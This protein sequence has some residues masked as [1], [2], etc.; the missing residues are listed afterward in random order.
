[1]Y[2]DDDGNDDNDN[3]DCDY[4]SGDDYYGDQG[5]DD[6]YGDG[7]C[8]DDDDDDD[9]KKKY[10]LKILLV[11]MDCT[12]T[13]TIDNDI[14][15]NPD[16]ECLDEHIRI[17]VKTRK[18]FNGRI[19]AKGK[20]DKQACMKDNFA[21]EKTKKPH[22]F[23]KFGTC[24]MR[25]LR[26]TDPRGMYYGITIV[27]SFHT[28]F[29]TKVDQAF[30]V[31][32][33]FEEAS[34]GLTAK[35]G[36][37]MIPTTEMEARHP[38]PGCS[39]SIHASSIN[40]IE[41]GRPAGT[42]IK[43][44]RIG[45]RVLHQ[46]H[47]DDQ[48]YGI[49]I[50]NCYVTDGFGKRTE[51]IDSNGCSID[52]ILI[53]SIRYSNDLQRAYGESTVFK[54]ADRPGVWFFCQI[55]MCMKKEGM[56]QGITPPACTAQ[57]GN[58]VYGGEEEEEE[59]QKGSG[60][61]KPL[62]LIASSTKSAKEEQK[63]KEENSENQIGDGSDESADVYLVEHGRPLS[64]FRP[65]NAIE[66]EES[67]G[68]YDELEI[69]TTKLR[70][71]GRDSRIVAKQKLSA[72]TTTNALV[73]AIFET[74]DEY[75]VNGK[76]DDRDTVKLIN[77]KEYSET[78]YDDLTIA[79]N[80]NDLLANLPDEVNAASLQKMFYDS[81]ANRRVLM[82]SFDYLMN[83][84]AWNSA[85]LAD[86]PL[87]DANE[88]GHSIG[89]NANTKLP[90]ISDDENAS[91]MIAGQLIIYDLDEEPPAARKVKRENGMF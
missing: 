78:N 27:V 89:Q 38:I 74:T 58:V 39:Y 86:K 52:P 32:C 24:G 69:T 57:T 68:I 51:V 59:V 81:V 23:L 70:S 1:M 2:D 18:I 20:A 71:A 12:V 21:Q 73:T 85:R 5:D 64:G 56:C 47:C 67:D 11:V 84:V 41:A 55:Q 3:D 19:Y 34:H 17:F 29:I 8:S 15:G 28:V 83:Q 37:S 35:F 65:K 36:V 66:Y 82:K 75:D 49:L 33:F 7:G 9:E 90:S 53:T 91:L 10:I 77:A 60:R 46:W 80:F 72:E 25:S 22:M 48:M 62:S 44:A 40:D 26:S 63:E 87:V 79:P 88:K 16:I 31:K 30:H 76:H 43:Y 42:V 4:G 14:I 54:F 45:D 61:I 50:N 13:V 6:D